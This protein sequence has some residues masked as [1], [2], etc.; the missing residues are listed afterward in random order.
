M[1]F[2]VDTNKKPEIFSV[3]LINSGN[4]CVCHV[5]YVGYFDGGEIL[6]AE[7]RP[8]WLKTDLLQ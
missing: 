6:K 7:E 2:C 5:G 1:N 4:F 3:F 8:V